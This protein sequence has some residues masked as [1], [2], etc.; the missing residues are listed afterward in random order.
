MRPSRVFRLIFRIFILIL[1]LSVTLIATLG[2]L[3]GLSILMG[4]NIGLDTDNADFNLQINNSTYEIEDFSF[5][6][7][8]NLTNSGLFD[9]ENLKLTIDLDM[10]YSHVDDPVPGVNTTRQ[11]QILTKSS[12]FGTISKGRT[13][14]FNFTAD[15]GD[16][17]IGV[18]PNFTSEVDWYRG[19]P[20][21]EF[22]ANLTI[23]LDYSI[24]LHTLTI[25]IHNL[26]VGGIPS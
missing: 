4:D 8:F 22:Y 21:I 6:L 12:N 3:S 1:T 5:A 9:L 18:F 13:G 11:I 15:F 10:N 20:A 7:P 17:I 16:F 24:G 2:G 23:S 19:T 14:N 26:P 25:G